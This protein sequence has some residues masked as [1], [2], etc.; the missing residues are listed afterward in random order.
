MVPGIQHIFCPGFADAVQNGA[1]LRIKPVPD[2]VI[3]KGAALHHHTAAV[4][5]K[6]GGLDP[7]PIKSALTQFNTGSRLAVHD[8]QHLIVKYRAILNIHICTL[9]EPE[10]LSRCKS[11]FTDVVKITVGDQQP[12]GLVCLNAVG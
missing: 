9:T 3:L 2:C 1:V 7:V 11:V 12:I 6:D 5:G 10:N 8:L 4:D